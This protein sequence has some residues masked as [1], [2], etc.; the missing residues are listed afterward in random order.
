MSR[1][2]A[3]HSECAQMID[4][5]RAGTRVHVSHG[6]RRPK[7]G[8]TEEFKKQFQENVNRWVFRKLR[9]RKWMHTKDL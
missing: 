5:Y 4:N 6:R 1:F 3:F 9:R 7:A 8:R 2:I